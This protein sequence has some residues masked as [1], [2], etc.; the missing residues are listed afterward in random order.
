MMSAMPADYSSSENDGARGE[1][2]RNLRELL[3]FSYE[4]L[5]KTEGLTD[6]A[7]NS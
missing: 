3:A 5:A 2:H 6:R 4:L 1:V 7:A